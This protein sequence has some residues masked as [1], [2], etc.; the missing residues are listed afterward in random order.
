MAK[1]NEI[2]YV[3]E[4]ARLEGVQ[5]SDVEVFLL[6][7]PFSAPRCHEYLMDVG[8]IMS[9]F[10]PKPAKILDIGVGSGWTSEMFAKAGYDV[11]GIDISP[12]MIALAKRRDCNARFLV[13]DYE[14]GPIE[15]TFDAAVIYDALH[16]ADN[17]YLVIKNIFDALAPGGVLITIEPGRGHS[18]ASYSLDA[19]A[20]FGTTE[21]DMPYRLQKT[22][23]KVAGF[24]SVAQHPRASPSRVSLLRWMI[25]SARLAMGMSS[26]VVAVK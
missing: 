15:G 10:P 1:A 24:R 13:S 19:V 17:E 9:F 14:A 4:I 25:N 7:K 20:K 12:D 5:L 22:H 26:V 23:M 18:S 11:T 16:H 3:R 21:K 6:N 8:Q 2:A